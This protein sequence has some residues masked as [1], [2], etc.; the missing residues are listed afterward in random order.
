MADRSI[1]EEILRALRRIT[2]A[3]DIHSRRL[4]N[5]YGLTGPQLVC[6]RALER[7]GETTPSRLAN[8][9]SLS[10][11][12]VTGIIDRLA[13]RQL[14]T[15]ERTAPDRRMVTVAITE[16]GRAL[17]A[18]APSPLQE[19]FLDKLQTLDPASQTRIR[20]TLEEVVQMMGGAEID[21]APLLSTTPV[22]QPL[23]ESD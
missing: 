10:Q 13:A 3:I 16:A 2:R 5:T 8:E 15:R 20:D 17:I 11:S 18:Q 12:T 9:L 21:A 7:A 23:E 6:L 1:D 22:T 19:S 14:L 4:V